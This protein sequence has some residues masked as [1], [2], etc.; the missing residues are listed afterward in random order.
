MEVKISQA[1]PM[2][3]AYIKARLVPMLEGSPGVGKS[4]IIHQIA[5][6]YGLKVIDLRL[7]QCEPTDLMGFPNIKSTPA[8]T[9]AG[10][11]PMDTF[12]LEG[13]PIPDGF[14]GWLLFLDEFSSAV[15]ATQAAAYKIVLDRMVG[16]HKLHKNV[17]IVCAGNKQTDNAIVE[18]MST[19]LQSRLVHMT[20]LCDH[21]EWIDWAVTNNFDSRITSYVGFKP[22]AVYTFQPDHTDKTYACPRTWE[23]ANELLKNLDVTNDLALPLLAGTISEGVAREFLGFCKLQDDLPKMT[24]ILT[25]PTGIM[26]PQEPS[27][28]WALSGAIASTA[29]NKNCEQL[30]KFVSRMPVEFQVVCLRELVRRNN[31]ALAKHAAVAKWVQENSVT[32]F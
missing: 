3:T 22:S 5:K 15:R 11:V 27:I 23:F 2:I 28:L 32:L 9:T 30:L 25:N 1:I 20:L 8:K 13:D 29:D 6:A 14:N 7:S 17:A 24:S 12:P 31:R 4:G 19:A 21:Q 18:E 16:Q 10:Y 26:V